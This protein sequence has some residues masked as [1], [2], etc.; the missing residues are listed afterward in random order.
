MR[1]CPCLWI[2]MSVVT[3]KAQTAFEEISADPNKSASVYYAYPEISEQYTLPPEGYTPFYISH[4]GR[5]GSRYLISDSE[6]QTV[7]EI[8]DKADA[9]GFLTDKGRVFVVGLKWFGE[10]QRV[11]RAAY[12]FG[13]STA[14]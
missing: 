12:S 3:S 13:I 8:L 10:M 1:F 9:V 11:G 4:Y 14:S 6:Y 2:G 7:M 5:H